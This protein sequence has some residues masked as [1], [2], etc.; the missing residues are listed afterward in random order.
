M[1][2]RCPYTREATGFRGDELG[3]AGVAQR[4]EALRVERGASHLGKRGIH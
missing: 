4:K 3:K 1:S 2:E